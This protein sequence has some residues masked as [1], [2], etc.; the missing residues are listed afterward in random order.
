MESDSTRETI[1]IMI[2]KLVI[3]IITNDILIFSSY[4]SKL[5]HHLGRKN[6]S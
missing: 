2:I 6:L 3:N 5:Y 4:F 1:D